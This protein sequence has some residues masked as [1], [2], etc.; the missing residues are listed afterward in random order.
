MKRLTIG[1]AAFFMMSTTT[2]AQEIFP[3]Y[4]SVPNSRQAE[5]L[6][7]SVT[8][9]DGI[10]RINNVSVPTIT[11]YQPAAGKQ[12]N[13]PAVVICP[14]GGYSI[15]AISHEGVDVAKAFN[16]WGVT[17]FVL[18]YRLPDDRTM[19]DKSIGPLQDAERAMQWVREH[20]KEY[21]INPH[22]VGIMGFSAGGH[23]ASTLS[24]HYKD[25][26][27]SNPGKVSLRPDF[28]VLIYPVISFSD[29][30]GHRGS[31]ERLIGK[32][33]AA[34]TI[35]KYSNELQVD[36]K[37]PPAFLVH[38]KDDKT[39]PWQNSQ[40]YY[41]ALLNNKVQARIF[42]YDKGG[43]GFGMHNKTSDQNWM[44]ALKEWM[45]QQHLL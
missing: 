30:L 20:A 45:Q 39:V 31:R 23:L 3:L 25:V 34:A 12:K 44:A 21:D 22:K 15:L 38:A 14:G 16:E 27:I 17:A 43:H 13:G 32:T 24:T 33:P 1:L 5:N 37:T 7:Q 19:T 6:E 42:Y 36:K 2:H 4:Q 41:D 28:S 18:K 9:T 26:V 10:T 29:S 11:V 40:Q 8:G 35:Q